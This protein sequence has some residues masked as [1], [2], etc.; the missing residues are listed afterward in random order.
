LDVVILVANTFDEEETIKC[1]RIMRQAGLSTEII[2]HRSGLITGAS[3]MTVRPD[4][5]LIDLDE[6][7]GI[8]LIIM[9]GKVPSAMALL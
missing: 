9:P 7:A 6:S 5:T 4:R 8:R 1:L 3:G 2:G